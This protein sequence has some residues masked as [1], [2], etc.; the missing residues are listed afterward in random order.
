METKWYMRPVKIQTYHFPHVCLLALSGIK[1]VLYQQFGLLTELPAIDYIHVVEKGRWEPHAHRLFKKAGS[2]FDASGR[3]MRPPHHMLSIWLNK[4][5]FNLTGYLVVK[6][7][8][9]CLPLLHRTD[10]GK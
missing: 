2:P 4:V 10:P 6:L 9:R 5:K 7:R 3:A 1:T 8:R